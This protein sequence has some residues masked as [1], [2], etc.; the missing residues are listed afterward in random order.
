MLKQE[1]QPNQPAYKLSGN[2]STLTLSDGRVFNLD[3][4]MAIANLVDVIPN[5][6]RDLRIDV[7][8]I[9][10]EL[11]EHLPDDYNHAMYKRMSKQLRCYAEFFSALFIEQK[12]GNN[13]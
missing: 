3:I 10:D 8:S 6:M 13:D 11:T 12:G 7:L 5:D 1:N 9:H 2:N 4:N